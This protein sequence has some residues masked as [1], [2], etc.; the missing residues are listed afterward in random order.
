MGRRRR[1]QPDEETAPRVSCRRD[2]E[3]ID[4]NHTEGPKVM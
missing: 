4:A 3:A 1:A 2:D